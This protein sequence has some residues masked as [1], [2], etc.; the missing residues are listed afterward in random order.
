MFTEDI[1]KPPL[2]DMDKIAG[3][4]ISITTR[5]LKSTIPAG[6]DLSGA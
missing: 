1:F 4:V 2:G 6:I 3:D 5:R